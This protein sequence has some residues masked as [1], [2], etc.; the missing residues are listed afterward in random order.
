MLFRSYRMAGSM[1]DISARKAD[2]E[3]LA[4]DAMHDPLTNLP[5]RA[6]FLDQVQHALERARRRSDYRAAVLLLDLDR[7]KIVN[8]SL[9][10]AIG[11]QLIIDV[12][13]RLKASLRP[14]DTLARTG[15]D[16]FAI[17]VEDLNN[18]SEASQIANQLQQKLSAPFEFQGYE[19]YTSV[20]IGIVQVEERYSSP[21]DLM[22]DA[23]AATYRAKANGRGGIEIFDI[24]MHTASM[25]L[26][27]LESELRRAIERHELRVYFQPIF[28]LKQRKITGF[29][30]LLRWQHPI[31]G[32]LLPAQ[33]IGL[34]EETGLILPIGRWVLHTA[35]TQA[36]Q[37]IKSGYPDIQIAVNI[38]AGQFRAAG[39]LNLVQETLRETGLPG[40]L[41][42]VEITENIA[43]QDVEAT[44]KALDDLTAMR[45][46]VLI[47]DFGTGYSS[48]NYLKR[49]PV[50][51][52]KIDQSFIRGIPNN[53]DDVAITSA[54]LAMA[55][56]LKIQVIAEGV[57]NR[58]Q[59]HFLLQNDCDQ[60]QGFWVSP[61]VP[62]VA[63]LR[64][65]QHG[66][67]E[68]HLRQLG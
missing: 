5:N 22:R 30:A 37:W 11:D 64:L 14:G 61:A 8:E 23:D 33:F 47:D 3:R 59:V 19:I 28:S 26:L 66:L 63:T 62:G 13:Q 50:A 51:A 57:E 55:K 53:S 34:A 24:Q 18:L 6:Y 21:Q 56:A 7:F 27:K 25:Q 52:L 1:S 44:S 65:L 15:G 16:E 46:Q 43:M 41:L 9:G 39:I 40:H 36:K 49:F 68:R 12:A 17:L 2:L 48:L 31:R 32:T 54:I 67:D 58:E 29:E 35:C 42:K 38:S 60:I 10:H 4:H 20:T 45:V